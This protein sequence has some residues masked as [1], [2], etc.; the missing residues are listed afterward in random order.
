PI[1]HIPHFLPQSEVDDAPDSGPPRERPYFLFVGRLEKIKGVQVLI[2]TF[3]DYHQADLVIAG[4][5][6][7]EA[8]LREMAADLSHVHF[9]GMI[10]HEVLRRYF[11]GAL[12]TLV[13]S[14]CYESFGMT[15]IESFTMRTPAIVH[16]LGALPE[17]VKDGGGLTYDTPEELVRALEIMR[18]QPDFRNQLGEQGYQL[19]MSHYSETRHL[20]SYYDLIAEMKTMREGIQ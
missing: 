5:G 4:R 11:R 15:I 13:P 20:N 12:A 16:N 6:N 10:G 17:V 2:D 3:R 14:I 7:Y 19:Y 18:T 1:R 8:T 9:L